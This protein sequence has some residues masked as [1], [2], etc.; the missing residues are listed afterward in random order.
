MNK[1]QIKDILENNYHNSEFDLQTATDQ[2]YDLYT[3]IE[4]S[5]EERKEY[6]KEKVFL[7]QDYYYS[8]EMMLEFFEY[9][10]ERGEKDRKMRFEKEK[11]F[12]I[13][14]ELNKFYYKTK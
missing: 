6:F 9:W 2:I 13:V 11:S 7:S 14:K 8:N 10:T 3:E 1:K 4:K 5:I 12:D